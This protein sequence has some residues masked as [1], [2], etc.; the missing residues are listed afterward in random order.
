MPRRAPR[1]L[2][3][4][5]LGAA[6][7]FEGKTSPL[8]HL[9]PAQVSIIGRRDTWPAR[10]SGCA[11]SRGTES[12]IP[13]GWRNRA[14]QDPA[15]RYQGQVSIARGNAPSNGLPRMCDRGRESPV[16]LLP[17]RDSRRLLAR[18]TFS[19]A[20]ESIEFPADFCSCARAVAHL[21]VRM[22]PRQE[23]SL[24]LRSLSARSN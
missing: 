20:H 7:R 22:S 17:P 13:T 8:Y 6:L 14:R 10:V 24:A 18:P 23:L 3:Y 9:Y 4:S 11:L 12:P 2:I 1:L 5:D 19:R 21:S 16:G 15:S